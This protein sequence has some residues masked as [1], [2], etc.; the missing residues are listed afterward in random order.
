MTEN[1]HLI[2]TVFP[3]GVSLGQRLFVDGDTNRVRRR[4]SC[5]E[6]ETRLIVVT[7][8]RPSKGFARHLR[9]VAKGLTP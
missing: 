5:V 8:I 7:H 9:R 4:V 1:E 6:S 3:H 2:E